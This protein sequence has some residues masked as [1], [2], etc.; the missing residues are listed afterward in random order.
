MCHICSAWRVKSGLCILFRRAKGGA[1]CR[2]RWC[3]CLRCVTFFF[4]SG[5]S[6]VEATKQHKHE[7]QEYSD[8]NAGIRYIKNGKVIIDLRNAEGDK[9]DDIAT[10]QRS[11]DKIAYSA[12]DDHPE[13]KLIDQ[14]SRIE[15]SHVEVDDHSYS[16]R[17][18]HRKDRLIGKHTKGCSTIVGIKNNEIMSHQ[19]EWRSPSWLKVLHNKSFCPLIECNND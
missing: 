5:R 1:I 6:A 7:E 16:K 4:R 17:N 3:R 2:R 9:I 10:M 8:R 11:I 18:Q 14:R 13:N 12:P 15:H 19:R